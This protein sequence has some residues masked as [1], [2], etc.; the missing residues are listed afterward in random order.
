[1]N[2]AP[3]HVHENKETFLLPADELALSGF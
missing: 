3:L 1:V 2:K